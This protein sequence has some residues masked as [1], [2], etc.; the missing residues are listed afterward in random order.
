MS[1]SEYVMDKAEPSYYA[2]IPADVR[3]D[4]KLSANAK[5]LY[6]EITAL[7]NKKGYCWA[8]NRHFAELYQVKAETISRWVSN[9]KTQKYI[10][11]KIVKKKGN[12][13][14]I[15]LVCAT[16]TYCQKSQEVLTKNAIAIDEKVKHNSKGNSKKN[17]KTNTLV[18]SAQECVF[19]DSLKSKNAV[20]E[21]PPEYWF[22]K[23]V[24]CIEARAEQL[25]LVVDEVE[26]FDWLEAGDWELGGGLKVNSFFGLD[27]ALQKW[28]S[29]C[30]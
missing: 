2:I 22:S 18:H 21:T 8:S 15:R 17:N 29:V 5:L 26:M 30:V 9:L 7:S 4:K 28:D 27:K 11:I 24:G 10:K 6:G 14:Q 19:E 12:Q 23:T 25:G 16:N 1:E 20:Q 3:Y 13:R